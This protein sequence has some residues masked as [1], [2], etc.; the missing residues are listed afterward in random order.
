MIK[1]TTEKSIN[2]GY[3]STPLPLILWLSFYYTLSPFISAD[4][5]QLMEGLV[6]A[7]I[8]GLVDAEV[9]EVKGNHLNYQ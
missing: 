1:P 2:I 9:S 7:L 6:D 8:E 3:L 5:H 4:N